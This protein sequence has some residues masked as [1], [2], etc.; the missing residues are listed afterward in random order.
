LKKLFKMP[1]SN[2]CLCRFGDNMRKTRSIIVVALLAV[3]GAIA[4]LIN[5]LL[6][7][8][9]SV[10][11]MAFLA[12]T[13]QIN[14]SKIA[15]LLKGYAKNVARLRVEIHAKLHTGFQ[16]YNGVDEDEKGHVKSAGFIR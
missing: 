8:G 9:A 4:A 7:L 2:F 16:D 13:R 5:P 1:L 15:M 3:A 6:I 14:L 10:S 12:I 11:I